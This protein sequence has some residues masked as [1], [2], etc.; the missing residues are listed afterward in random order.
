M[1]NY[2]WT[3]R[4]YVNRSVVYP[5]FYVSSTQDTQVQRERSAFDTKYH[6]CHRIIFC[7]LT[8]RHLIFLSETMW[9]FCNF[10]YRYLSFYYKYTLRFSNRN[11]VL[12]EESFLREYNIR[13]YVDDHVYTMYQRNQYKCKIVTKCRRFTWESFRRLNEIAKISGYGTGWK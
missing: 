10:H 12:V 1:F 6:S 8:S 4:V 2:G 5:L 13:D 9:N 11:L 7:I 3:S